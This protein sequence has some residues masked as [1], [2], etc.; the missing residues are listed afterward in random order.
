VPA[1]LPLAIRDYFEGRHE[2]GVEA[3]AA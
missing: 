1:A 3:E 2:D